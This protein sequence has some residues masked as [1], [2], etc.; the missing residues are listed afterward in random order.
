[1]QIHSEPD[2]RH[3]E[4]GDDLHATAQ[5]DMPVVGPG[6]DAAPSLSLEVTE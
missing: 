5:Q 2:P 6:R 1:M 4:G 3:V